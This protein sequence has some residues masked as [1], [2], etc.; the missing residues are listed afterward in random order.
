MMQRRA[1][2]R[3]ATA[4]DADAVSAL[5]RLLVTTFDF[6]DDAFRS[7]FDRLRSRDDVRTLEA[8]GGDVQGIMMRTAPH[9]LVISPMPLDRVGLAAAAVLEHDPGVPRVSGPRNV[10]ECFVEQL[11]QSAEVRVGANFERSTL[12]YVLGLL[13][14]PTFPTG[15]CHVASDEDYG[16][17]HFWWIGF[18]EDTAVEM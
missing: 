13:T 2:I 15:L 16:L 17:L 4:D 5:A 3:P 7:A 14:V 11:M 6:E 10:V 1:A 12:V 9:K 18:G 8:P